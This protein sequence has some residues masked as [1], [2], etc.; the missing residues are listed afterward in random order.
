VPDNNNAIIVL[1]RTTLLSFIDTARAT[2][3]SR[4]GRFGR[5]S[6]AAGPMRRVKRSWS[7]GGDRGCPAPLWV[8]LSGRCPDSPGRCWLKAALVGE[9]PA[10][11][12][13]SGQGNTGGT[14]RA[15][16]NRSLVLE[17][18]AHPPRETGACKTMDRPCV[19]CRKSRDQF[20]FTYIAGGEVD[21]LHSLHVGAA[22]NQ[23][24]FKRLKRLWICPECWKEIPAD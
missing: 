22:Q 2:I 16:G 15:L 5:G 13:K 6:R 9:L 23:L 10:N 19:V 24:E 7:N 1:H 3:A 8:E 12:S 18:A 17:R 4:T 11:W 20:S 14:R 21:Q